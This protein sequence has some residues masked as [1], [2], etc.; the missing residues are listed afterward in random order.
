MTW[1]ETRGAAGR[2]AW[3]HESGL[4]RVQDGYGRPHHARYQVLSRTAPAAPWVE[5]GDRGSLAAAF[6]LGA[7]EAAHTGRPP[8]AGAAAT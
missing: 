6:D 2:R 3:D 7:R 5:S 4:A 1:T 8:V